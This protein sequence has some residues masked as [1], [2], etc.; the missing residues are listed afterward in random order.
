[1][2]IT[3]R[4]MWYM[5]IVGLG[6]T[7]I[8]SYGSLYYAFAILAP[9]VSR[10]YGVELSYVFGA[11]SIALSIGGVAAPV[12]GRYIDLRGG[13]R[14]LAVGSV[15][16]AI[17]LVLLSQADGIVLFVLALCLV[18]L[19]STLTLY[20]AA[21]AAIAHVRSPVDTRRA[22]SQIA[23]FGGFASTVFW[24][25]T[26]FLSHDLSWSEVYLVFA[27]LHIL[28]CLPIHLF[29]LN[30]GAE[31]S[32][33]LEPGAPQTA[34]ET[35]LAPDQHLRAMVW[36]VSTFC[37]TG[38]IYSALNV[39]WVGT[40]ETIGIDAATAVAAGALMGPAQVGIRLID[41]LFGGRLHP[42]VTTMIASVVLVM[43]LLSVF[44]LGN[45]FAAA[46]AFAIFFGISQGLTSIVRGTVPLA[47]FGVQGYATRLG[48]ITAI[49]IVVTSV[50]P[51]CFALSLDLGGGQTTLLLTALL[52]AASLL[53]LKLIPKPK[54]GSA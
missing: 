1:M 28:I 42:V 23:L 2:N 17:A 20:D 48:G 10:D 34:Q 24:P 47:L 50:A 13:R 40:F 8:I 45:G 38:F 44:V 29:A 43:G 49:R 25:L 32:D 27:A 30:M 54:Y 15:A 14:A 37:L 5:P 46:A 4:I 7:Q 39:H 26:H 19:A 41:M 22:I 53:T 35:V 51:F 31:T 52:A 36:L 18:E 11:F 6:I 33:R 16:S 12:A 21:F 3:N 9:H